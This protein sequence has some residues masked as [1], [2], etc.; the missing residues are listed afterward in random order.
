MKIDWRIEAIKEL[1]KTEERR[2]DKVHT[3]NSV[4]YEGRVY[5][6]TITY[7]PIK[8]KEEKL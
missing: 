8:I 2:G 1:L 5:C 6:I 7:E 4:E 3:S